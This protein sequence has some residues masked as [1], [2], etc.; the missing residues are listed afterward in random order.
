MTPISRRTCDLIRIAVLSLAAHFTPFFHV[1]QMQLVDCFERRLKLHGQFVLFCGEL[2]RLLLKD[3]Q[4]LD[5]I[6]HREIRHRGIT[7]CSHVFPSPN[8]TQ[9]FITIPD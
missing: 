1:S 2:C 5:K 8:D 3:I 7:V 4:T 6:A 9:S